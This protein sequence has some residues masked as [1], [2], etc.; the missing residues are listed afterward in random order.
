MEKEE[1]KQQ[2]EAAANPAGEMGGEEG[3]QFAESGTPGKKNINA[4]AAQK[5][6]QNVREANNLKQVSPK[7]DKDETKSGDIA[8]G[9]EIEQKR[10][11]LLTYKDYFAYINNFLQVESEVQL[12]SITLVRNLMNTNFSSYVAYM[13]QNVWEDQY[14]LKSLLAKNPKKRKKKRQK[15]EMPL[16]ILESLAYEYLSLLR[17]FCK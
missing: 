4:N 5:T 7:L 2:N 10:M 9:E 12:A 6:S 8:A 13:G 16:D 1:E 11:E 17:I 14:G 15:T 3:Q